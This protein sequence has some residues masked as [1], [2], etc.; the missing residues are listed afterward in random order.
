M[1]KIYKACLIGT[2]A[3]LVLGA[4]GCTKLEARDQL[5][6]GVESYKAA[7]FNQAIDHF[8]KA[9]QLDP[10]LVNAKLYLATA[11]QSQ[12]VPGAPSEDNLHMAQQALDEYKVILDQDPSNANA[13]A[14][15]ARLNYD[16]GNLDEAE[17]YYERSL[18]VSPN[19]PEAY[20]TLGA[21]AYQKTNPGILAARKSL[22]VTDINKPLIPLKGATAKA[23]KACQNLAKQDMSIIQDGIDQ[24]NKAMELR[25][26]YADAMSYLNLLYRNRADLSC[27]NA[28][29][30]NADIA[31]A[32]DFEAR[33]VAQNKADVAAKN[34]AANS[35][36]SVTNQ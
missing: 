28:T 31:T 15:V 9:I 21:I 20:Y 2:L 32:N 13:I 22:G 27:G 24:L 10:T 8:Q 5:N 35:T 4:A 19:D 7:K 6:Q 16:M 34:K 12:F 14:G 11:Y 30:Y 29:Q 1:N 36:P 26:N 25:P 3:G 18:T 23:K 33:A 17:S